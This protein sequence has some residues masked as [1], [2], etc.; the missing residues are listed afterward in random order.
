VTVNTACTGPASG[1]CS[2]GWACNPTDCPAP[3]AACRSCRSNADCGSGGQCLRRVCDGFAACYASATS[4]CN[5]IDGAACPAVAAYRSCTSTSQCAAGSA[6]IPAVEGVSDRV[7]AASC[8]VSSE[9][10]PV[11]S[12]V[13]ATPYCFNNRCSLGCTAPG[14]CPSDM[15]CRMGSTGYLYCL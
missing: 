8:A 9:C 6:C 13:G 2:G 10:P 5:T 11:P 4:S 7:C 3:P 14:Q 1:T 12:T 15:T